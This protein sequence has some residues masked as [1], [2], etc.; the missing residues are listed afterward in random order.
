MSTATVPYKQQHYKLHTEVVVHY[1]NHNRPLIILL[2]K[3]WVCKGYIYD[4]WIGRVHG[5]FIS[6]YIFFHS[7]CSKAIIRYRNEIRVIV[8][9]LQYYE[10]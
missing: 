3:E 5:L 6:L 10:Y 8:V 4:L 1:Q 7:I 9:I 2:K